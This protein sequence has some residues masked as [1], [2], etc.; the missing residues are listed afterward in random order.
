MKATQVTI[1]TQ[2]AES[3]HSEYPCSYHWIGPY[4]QPH[5]ATALSCY[6]EELH[7]PPGV[8]H[9]CVV[10]IGK[11]QFLI[12]AHYSP[13]APIN[14]ALKELAPGFD[15]RGELV[16]VALGRSVP[17][18]RRM[19]LRPAVTAINKFLATSLSHI[20]LKLPTPVSII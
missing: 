14:G 11:D 9:D 7:H 12:S 19:K 8:F 6:G 4:F 17:Y 13:K 16:I 1:D 10:A 18:L 20:H 3:R 15:W 2:A 5:Y